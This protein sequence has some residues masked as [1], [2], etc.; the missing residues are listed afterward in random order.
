MT[1][2]RRGGAG[3]GLAYMDDSISELFEDRF[4]VFEV[5]LILK[6]CSPRFEEEQKVLIVPHRLEQFLGAET[7][8]PERHSALEARFRKQERPF[9]ILPEPCAEEPGL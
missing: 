1:G 7:D 5:E 2:K 6:A 8:E 4:Q 9:R 3:N